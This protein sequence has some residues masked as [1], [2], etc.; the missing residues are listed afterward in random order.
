MIAA[1]DVRTVEQLAELADGL[2]QDL[3]ARNPGDP[4]FEQFGFLDGRETVLD[5]CGFGELGC[6]VSHLLYMVHESSISF[7]S[8][9]IATLHSL[10]DRIGVRNGYAT[11]MDSSSSSPT[12]TE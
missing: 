11:M 2:L 9:A 8:D 6:A 10:A 3:Y 7:P 12:N 5:F 4:T 1:D